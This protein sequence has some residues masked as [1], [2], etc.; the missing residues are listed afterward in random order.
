MTEQSEC[1]RSQLIYED[2]VAEGRKGARLPGPKK[3]FGQTTQVSFILSEYP[4]NARCSRALL[5]KS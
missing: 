4:L 3:V 1:S 2:L 5:N